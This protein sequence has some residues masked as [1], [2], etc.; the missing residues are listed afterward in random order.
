MTI[1]LLPVTRE[2]AHHALTIRAAEPELYYLHFN[3]HW[4]GHTLTNNDIECAF[5][6][7]GKE[8]VGFVA[9]GQ[10]YKD[11]YLT[12]PQ[13]QNLAELH[14]IVI[15]PEHQ[16]KGVGKQ[17][18]QLIAKQLEGRGY[19]SL[20]VAHHPDSE[21]AARFYQSLGF[22]EVGL[23]DDEDRLLEIDLP[24]LIQATVA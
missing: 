9:F 23:K 15:Q 4:L 7:T 16:H 10:S 22:Y 13:G 1:Q 20:Q 6:S 2:N 21:K 14:H 18:I 12:Q 8:I 5:I 11:Q 17:A 3:T 19:C 24:A